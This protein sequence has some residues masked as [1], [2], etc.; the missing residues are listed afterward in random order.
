[1]SNDAMRATRR[2]VWPHC[3]AMVLAGLLASG[4]AVGP[5]FTPPPPPALDRYP[6]QSDQA[7]L[8]A[9]GS[10]QTIELGRPTDAAWWRLFGSP[11]LNDLVAAGLKSSPTLASARQA[12]EQSRDQARA[13]AGV[14]FPSVNAA[15]DAVRERTNAVELGQKGEGSTFSLYTLSGSVSYVLD[16]FGGERRQVEAL[17][18]QADY[19]RHAVGAAYLLLTGNIVDAAVARAGYADEVATL[20][21]IVKLDQ[22]QRDILKA[23]Y[24]AG[25]VAWS[26]ELAAEQ[27]LDADEQSLALGRQRL[28]ASLTLLQTLMGREPAEGSPPPPALDDLTVPAD[29]PVSLPSQL[30]HERPDILEA[31]ANVH[32]ASAQVGVATAALFPS[33]SITGDYGAASTSLASLASPMGRFWSIGPTIEVPIFRGGALWYGRKAAQAA[34][35]KSAADYR[36]TVLAALEQ[37]ADSVKALGADAEIAQASRQSLDAAALNGKLSEANRA[38]GL[39]ADFDAMTAD[40]ATDRARLSLTA[41]KSQRLQDIVALYV[42][43]G[44]GWT[45][46]EPGSGQVAVSA[47]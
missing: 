32:Q 37:V 15:A 1:M 13:G 21:D 19:Q 44:G 16:L 45:G 34:F 3:A 42:A 36:Q 38:S 14:F 12:L 33:I 28:A 30:V 7:R 18:A 39:I 9:D 26:A 22:A 25:T 11:A 6:D 4:C 8:E 43:C 29:A 17:N 46:Q 20:A 40:I 5:N 27:Q 2:R 23:E 31:E 47:K 41:A 35:V 24:N 10:A